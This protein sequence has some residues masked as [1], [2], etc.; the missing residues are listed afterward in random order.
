MSRQSGTKKWT[1]NTGTASDLQGKRE[2][3]SDDQY[4]TKKLFRHEKETTE[5]SASRNLKQQK[6]QS[7]DN[8]VLARDKANDSQ[9]SLIASYG[10]FPLALAR[11]KRIRN[12]VIPYAE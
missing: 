10:V 9:S 8:T 5:V 2:K 7:T 12:G 1:T 6:V 4:F 3:K 11:A